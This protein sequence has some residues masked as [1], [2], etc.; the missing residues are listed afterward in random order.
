MKF[1]KIFVLI[2]F[3]AAC[4]NSSKTT[5]TGDK[6]APSKKAEA[7]F[8]TNIFCKPIVQM[9]EVQLDDSY[10]RTQI[11]SL[12]KVQ[13]CACIKYQYSGCNESEAILIWD[14]SLKKSSPP[15]AEMQ[16]RVKFAGSCEMLLTDSACFSLDN[17][18]GKGDNILLQLNGQKRLPISF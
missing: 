4:K 14:G 1:F 15:I 3:I 2:C 18:K 12:D 8:V 13:N 6:E 7:E 9:N 16:L 5:T 17:L 11:L 10:N